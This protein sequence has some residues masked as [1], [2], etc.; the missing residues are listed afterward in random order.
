VEAR[1]AGGSKYLF[2]PVGHKLLALNRSLF[3]CSCQVVTW[4][5]R[6]KI[7]LVLAGGRG[8]KGHEEARGRLPC[9]VLCNVPV[10]HC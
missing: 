7:G 2:F 4:E 6:K 8:W 10:R 9:R 1:C 3:K 5:G